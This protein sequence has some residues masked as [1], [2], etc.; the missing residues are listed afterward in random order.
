MSLSSL[1]PNQARTVY[2]ITY[3]QAVLIKIPTSS[4]FAEL[5]VNDFNKNVLYDRCE[6]WVSSMKKHETSGFH[7][8]LAIKLKGVYRWLSVK[9]NIRRNSGI[10][11]NFFDFT[12]GYYNAYGYTTKQDQFYLLSDNHP[13]EIEAPPRT[14]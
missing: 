4:K 2:L 12:T 11:L 6:F 9:E 8:L 10:V 3:S 7:Y 14:A 13:P 1:R 5:I